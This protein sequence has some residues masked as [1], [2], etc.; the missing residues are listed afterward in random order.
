MKIETLDYFKGKC[1]LLPFNDPQF[2]HP[3]RGEVSALIKL[4]NWSH[5]DLRNLLGVAF[6]ERSNSSSTVTSW[7]QGEKSEASKIKYD[8]W[9]LILLMAGLVTLDEQLA[10]I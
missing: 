9:R 5:K 3:T 10:S 6:S 1:S 7:Q 8:S 4:M 2:K